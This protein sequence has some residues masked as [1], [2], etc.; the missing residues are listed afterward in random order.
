MAVIYQDPYITC[1]DDAIEVRWYYLWGAKH[2]PYSTIRSA[3]RV[4]LDWLHGRGRIWGTANPRYWASLDPTRTSK[5]AALILDLSRS[6]SPLITPDDVQAVQDII[7]QRAGLAEIPY[8]G[9][10]PIL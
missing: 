10:G 7:R 2:I 5:D 1:N 9:V 6:V 3:R 4:D 8:A